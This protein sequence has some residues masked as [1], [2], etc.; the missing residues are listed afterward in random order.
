LRYPAPGK[1]ATS[2]FSSCPSAAGLE[3]FT[4]EAIAD[5]R[6]IA[7]K[8]QSSQFA[9]DLAVSDR[10]WWTGAFAE[11]QNADLGVHSVRFWEPAAQTAI[12]EAIGK[13]CGELLVRDSIEVSIGRSGFSDAT[14]AL[15]FLDRSGRPM[16]Y[17][18]NIEENN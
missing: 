5:A 3:Q 18:A 11:Y 10:S 7:S 8:Y 17:D 1:S 15:Y 4:P 9:S 2:A 6:M 13:A 12:G 14:G 16:V